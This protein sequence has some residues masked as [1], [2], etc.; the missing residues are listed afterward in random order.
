M[1]GI[2]KILSRCLLHEWMDA[3]LSLTLVLPV[4]HLGK[5]I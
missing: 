3:W 4:F 2:E 1:L 5:L